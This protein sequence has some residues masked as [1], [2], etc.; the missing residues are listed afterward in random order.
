MSIVFFNFKRRH[1]FFYSILLLPNFKIKIYLEIGSSSDARVNQ[2]INLDWQFAN[3]KKCILKVT[4]NG[5]NDR[6]VP[7]PQIPD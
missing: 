6:T 7:I 3:L 4:A 2:I 5:P 1:N